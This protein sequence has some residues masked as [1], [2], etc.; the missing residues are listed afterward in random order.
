MLE[1]YHKHAAERSKLGITPLQLTAEQTSQLCEL[2][3][4]PPA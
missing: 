4:H 2:L 3:K 1:N